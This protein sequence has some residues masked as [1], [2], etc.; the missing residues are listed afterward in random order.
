MNH[1]KKI[2]L[3]FIYKRTG[4]EAL[5][6]SEM[7]LT[8]SMNLNWCSPKEAKNFIKNC[9]EKNLLIEEK[10]VLKPNFKLEDVDIPV[11]FKPSANF[12][13][14]K[15]NGKPDG[16]K[17]ESKNNLISLIAKKTDKSIEEINEEINVISSE[18][19]LFFDVAALLYAKEYDIELEKFIKDT[20][21]SV[22]IQ[23][24]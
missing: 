2:V 18:K 3:A 4:K 24:K 15:I 12:F 11:G 5:S 21:E 17:L 13:E 9:I 16:K 6:F 8:I 1:E 20:E 14:K 22:F 23:N 10:D 7:Y 19:N